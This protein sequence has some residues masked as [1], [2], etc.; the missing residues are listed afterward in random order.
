MDVRVYINIAMSSILLDSQNEA[1][2]FLRK[3]L[4]LENYFRSDIFLWGSVQKALQRRSGPRGYCYDFPILD[5]KI[6][7]GRKT[8]KLVDFF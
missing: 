6:Q 2:E 1:A 8:K 3:G 4:S 7:S 5:L